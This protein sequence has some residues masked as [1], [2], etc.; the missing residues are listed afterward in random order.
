MFDLKGNIY[1][2]D[3]TTID[4]CMSLF[5]WAKFRKKKGGIK[6]HTLFD[7]EAGVSTFAYITE[8]KVHDVKAMDAIPYEAGSY[9]IFDRGYNDYKRLHTTHTI[10]ATFVVRAKKNVK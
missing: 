4:L 5:E 2:F 9:Y 3:S 7:V 10:G 1:A 6:V 8:A